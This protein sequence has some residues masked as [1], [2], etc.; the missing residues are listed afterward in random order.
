[1]RHGKKFNHLGR[2]KGHRKALLKN[3]TNSLVE[4]KRINTTVAKAK[5]LRVFVEPLITKS[6]TDS[7]HSRRVV[8]GYL[9]NKDT[10]K[11]LFDEIGPKVAGRPGG[12][13]RIIKTGFRK[14]DG[15]EMAM[16]E[17][18]DY[19]TVYS[20]STASG[21]SGGRRRRG[22]KKSSGASAAAAATTASKQEEE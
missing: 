18:V 8:F 4:Y 9:Q 15:A 2:K 10:V 12:Y 16:I 5:A 13:T 3:L 20:N 19:N 14:G 7:M 22:K 11:E 17:L 21:K 1:M 6:K